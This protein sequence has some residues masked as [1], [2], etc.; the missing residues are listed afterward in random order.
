MVMAALQSHIGFLADDKLEGRR[1][2]SAG[3]KIAYEYIS[4]KMEEAGLVPKGEQGT[5][6]QQFEVQEGREIKPATFLTINDFIL[7][8]NT[9]Y[10]PL[11]FSGNGKVTSL[12]QL[13]W[14][15]HKVNRFGFGI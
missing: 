8:L 6:I 10:F 3:E 14:Q 7:R 5:F 15:C 13:P 11:S 12:H 9:D 4:K 1:T 2:G